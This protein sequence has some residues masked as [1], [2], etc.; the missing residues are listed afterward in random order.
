MN[1]AELTATMEALGATRR[2]YGTGRTTYWHLHTP[3]GPLQFEVDLRGRSRFASV[4]VDRI[5][6]SHDAPGHARAWAEATLWPILTAAVERHG[7]RSR[8][9]GYA[10]PGCQGAYSQA[11]VHKDDLPAVLRLWVPQEAAWQAEGSAAR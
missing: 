5:L 2:H 8:R 1:T 6:T 10:L 9:H 3:T 11:L 4:A 7:S